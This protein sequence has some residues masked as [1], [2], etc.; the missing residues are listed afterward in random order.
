MTSIDPTYIH[1]SHIV[2][3]E[4]AGQ[5]F[6]AVAAL[7][8]DDFSRGAL[9]A[10]IKSGALTVNGNTCKPKQKVFEGDQLELKASQ[11]KIERWEPEPVEFDVVCE[12]DHVIV[13]NKHAGL[14]V[15]PGA[16]MPDGTLLN[17]LLYRYPELKHLPR[18]GIVHRLD[19]ETTGV[20]VIAR[21]PLAV[22]SLVEQLQ[23]RSMGRTYQA[24]T[25]GVTPIEGEVCEPMGRH[26]KHRTKMA[27]V[28]NGKP[29]TTYYRRLARL[30]HYSHIECRLATGRT[31]QIRVHMTHAG[32]PLVGDPVY[33]TKR[34]LAP[35]TRA[36]TAEAV[37]AFKR[38]ALHAHQ[39]TL[40]HPDTG[41]SMTTTVE[42]P[43][44]FNQLLRVL[45]N[46]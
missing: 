14:V 30:G 31:H 8:F 45:T 44:D 18:A 15:H 37:H 38:Q 39:L 17:G 27:V 26:P 41:E 46:Q 32:F 13:V 7:V 1:R 19:K 6:D 3:R 40:I 23:D 43:D 12:D 33:Q 9:Q 21:S 4:L 42:P 34:R 2:T 24:V 29:A 11:V 5:R 28:P 16:G 36:A 25:L 22:H 20:M 10:W 35:N